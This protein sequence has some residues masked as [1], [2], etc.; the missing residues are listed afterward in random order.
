MFCSHHRCDKFRSWSRLFSVR[1]RDLFG[2]RKR[3]RGHIATHSLLRYFG[4][5]LQRERRASPVESISV[6]IPNPYP[7]PG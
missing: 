1:N 5:D 6:G 2:G 4:N 7:A 3:R